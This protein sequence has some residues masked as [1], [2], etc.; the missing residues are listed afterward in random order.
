MAARAM[1]RDEIAMLTDL[2]NQCR[3][4]GATQTDVGTRE[5]LLYL[6]AKLDAK[7]ASLAKHTTNSLGG[8]S[9]P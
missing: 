7:L 9:H 6:A 1:T 3:K 8:A 4:Q 5:R 2:A